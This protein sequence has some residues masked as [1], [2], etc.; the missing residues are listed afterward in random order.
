MS[1]LLL[2]SEGRV[3]VSESSCEKKLYTSPNIGM[4]LVMSVRRIVANL[5]C[6]M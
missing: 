1:S 4:S 3:A 5:S 2:L 6:V